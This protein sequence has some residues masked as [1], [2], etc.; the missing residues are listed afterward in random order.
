MPEPNA[1]ALL[2]TDK[3]NKKLPFTFYFKFNQQTSAFQ[4]EYSN[5]VV[6]DMLTARIEESQFEENLSITTHD[7]PTEL[8]VDEKKMSSTATNEKK[9]GDSDLKAADPLK[10][11]YAEGIK[12][13]RLHEGHIGEIEEEKSE[14]EEE[15]E[16]MQN[17]GFIGLNQRGDGMLSIQRIDLILS[18]RN[19]L[20][21]YK[22]FQN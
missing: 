12:T 18:N 20:S 1:R 6:S 2:A 3:K 14:D 22:S 9:E 19:L 5:D 4:G 10:I 13:M 16:Y 17:Y 21:V 7:R 15:E 8:N 11:N